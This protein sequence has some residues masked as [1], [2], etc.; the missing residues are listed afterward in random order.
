MIS[1][2]RAE[3]RNGLPLESAFS[4]LNAQAGRNWIQNHAP[5]IQP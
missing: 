1:L 4:I 5:R 3:T 2:D